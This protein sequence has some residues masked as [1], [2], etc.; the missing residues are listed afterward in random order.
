MVI[1][2]A[3]ILALPVQHARRH[4][5]GTFAG[6]INITALQLNLKNLTIKVSNTVN[7]Q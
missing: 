1:L 2:R 7:E 4:R 6:T 5:T 3:G